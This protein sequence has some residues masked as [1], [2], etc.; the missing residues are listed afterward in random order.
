M[1][2]FF[3]A[4]ASIIA[5]GLFAFTYLKEWI[6]VKFLGEELILQPSNNINYPYFHESEA[7][8]LRVMLIFGLLFLWLLIASVFFIIKKNRGMVFLC[9][10]LSM[11]TILAMMINSAI[12]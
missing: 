4:F 7:L 2:R 3:M 1:D 8:Y 9:F 12:K 11:L 6:S 10:I 5:S